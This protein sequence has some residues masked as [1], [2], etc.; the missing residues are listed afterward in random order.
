MWRQGK[1]N[2]IGLLS[3]R[4]SNEPSGKV[5]ALKGEGGSKGA[6]DSLESPLLNVVPVDAKAAAA[7]GI[8]SESAAAP[9]SSASSGAALRRRS[10]HSFPIEET[11]W[12]ENVEEATA[13][14]G[15]LAEAQMQ[16]TSQ[17]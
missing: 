7:A 4:S 13:A 15:L 6:S 1:V 5:A 2:L 14:G 10:V 17:V 3:A 12:L 11:A 9:L 8:I 16:P